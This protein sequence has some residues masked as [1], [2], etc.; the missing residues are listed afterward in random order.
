MASERQIAANRRNALRSTGPR[1]SASKQRVSRNAYRHGLS[2]SVE[3]DPVLAEQVDQ[4]ARKI[5]GN[6]KD[7]LKFQYARQVA[8]AQLDLAR[9]RQAKIALLHRAMALWRTIQRRPLW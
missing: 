5:D 4:L 1:S 2:I 7:E 3:V 9:V 8:A 6:S